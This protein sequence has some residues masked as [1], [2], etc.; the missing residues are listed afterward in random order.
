MLPFW[1]KNLRK[2]FINGLDQANYHG[3]KEVEEVSEQYA[4]VV[5]SKIF[6]DAGVELHTIQ[7]DLDCEHYYVP[8]STS[9]HGHLYIYRAV[10][11]DQYSLLLHTL[12]GLGIIQRGYA[13]QLFSYG[14][15]FL[16]L[17]G[18]KKG[19]NSVTS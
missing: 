18:V 14:Q 8:S 11:R 9:G 4:N 16:R 17:P 7:L 12:V 10:N 6:D 1:F 5:G 19:Q 2:Y 15:T 13:D 3:G